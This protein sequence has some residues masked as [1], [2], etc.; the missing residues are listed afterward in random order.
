MPWSWGTPKE[1]PPGQLM[2][3]LIDGSAPWPDPILAP[4][5]GEAGELFY[6]K[7]GA[8]LYEEGHAHAG[9]FAGASMRVGSV[10]LHA[11]ESVGASLNYSP[12]RATRP[13]QDGRGRG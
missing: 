9:R 4:G 6:R 13:G 2:E 1:A 10:R 7:A 3:R 5:V 12:G 8:V 11:G